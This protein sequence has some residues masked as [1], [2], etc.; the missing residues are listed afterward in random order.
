M[1]ASCSSSHA[2]AGVGLGILLTQALDELDGERRRQG[3][4]LERPERQAAGPAVRRGRAARSPARRRSWRA[5]RPCTIRSA[6]RR[7]FST[8][9]MRRAIGTAQSS[10]MVSG[11]IALESRGRSAR[12][13]RA[14]SG[15]RCGRRR[16]RPGRAREDSP[17]SG[18]VGELGKLAVE[19]RR[20]I[21]PDLPD[22]R[23]H[24]VEVVD[25][26]LRG[27][28]DRRLP[29]GSPPRVCDSTGAGRARCPARV[30]TGG[31]RFHQRAGSS[32]ARSALRAPRVARR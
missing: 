7:R 11:C 4:G 29:P 19:P 8:S 30:A 5:A 9:T 16:P 28:R 15:C 18:T 13:S 25:E 12:A 21:L 6:S 26:P 1:A 24:D 32:G 17:R 14:R 3:G 27:R 22:R 23:V 31:G 10:P 20:E 2:S